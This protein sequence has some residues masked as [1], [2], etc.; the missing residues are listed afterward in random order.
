MVQT[1]MTTTRRALGVAA[2]VLGLALLAPGAARADDALVKRGEYLTRAA[3]CAACHNSPS[4][5]AW[6]GGR[7]FR[8][9]MG[10]LYSPNITPDPDTG[11]GRYTDD[12]WVSMMHDGIGRG[13]K[14]LYPA[15]PYNSYTGMSRD[16]ALA[17]KAYMFAQTP[18]KATAPANRMR[19]PFD[20]R[21]LM[22]GWNLFNNPDKRLEPVADKSAEWNRGAYLVEA[23]GH[24]AQCHTPRNFMQG[25]SGKHFAGAPQQGWMAYNMTSD[26]DHGIGGWSQGPGLVG[27][28]PGACQGRGPDRPAQ[29]L[30]LVDP[31]VAPAL[32]GLGFQEGRLDLDRRAGVR[33]VDAEDRHAQAQRLDR[34]REPLQDR[35]GD[36]GPARAERGVDVARGQGPRQA[37][38]GRPGEQAAD[39]GGAEDVR[40]RVGDPVLHHAPDPRQVVVAGEVFPL[41]GLVAR[42]GRLDP[43]ELEPADLVEPDPDAPVDPGR[44]TPVRPRPPR[45]LDQP[46]Q[47]ADDDHLA[48]LDPGPARG[49]DADKAQA[50]QS[51][52]QNPTSHGLPPIGEA[53]LSPEG[54]TSSRISSS[55]G[56]LVSRRS[57]GEPAERTRVARSSRIAR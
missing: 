48:R 50:D 31:P 17:I 37:R 22:V 15:M 57:R 1:R 2:A 14:H 28:G 42:P 40:R 47:T 25:L 33:Q 32:G 21:W 12:E 55:T 27:R 5:Q 6:V 49:A 19:F 51:Q 54:G 16:D 56:P 9:P 7:E 24:C 36:L 20:Q 35:A 46:A 23:L 53:T 3:D 44:P 10:V 38:L 11:I 4:G 8:L 26:K 18:V 43:A 39:V 41:A 52:E 45:R 30:G 29:R 13:G 34:P